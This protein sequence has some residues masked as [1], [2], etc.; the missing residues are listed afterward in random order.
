MR[1]NMNA[2]TLFRPQQ[3][4]SIIAPFVQLAAELS[5]VQAMQARQK[6]VRCEGRI[7]V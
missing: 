5:A 4:I 7:R 2:A 3:L 6:E 1:I